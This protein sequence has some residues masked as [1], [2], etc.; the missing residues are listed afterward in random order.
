LNFGHRVFG[1]LIFRRFGIFFGVLISAIRSRPNR[2]LLRQQVAPGADLENNS[3][4]FNWR[5]QSEQKK[6]E[7]V[8]RNIAIFE[9]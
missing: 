4:G 9:Y 7:N 5:A 8:F 6:M 3:G 2:V 1:H